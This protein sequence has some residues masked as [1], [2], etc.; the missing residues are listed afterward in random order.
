MS[1]EISDCISR[2]Y[3]LEIDKL[4]HWDHFLCLKVLIFHRDLQFEDKKNHS[5]SGFQMIFIL[6]PLLLVSE[7]GIQSECHSAMRTGVTFFKTWIFRTNTE[8]H[9]Q[10]SGWGMHP[11]RDVIL[12]SSV[13]SCYWRSAKSKIRHQR[14]Q[15]Y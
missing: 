9:W 7:R 14:Y 4:I 11:C 5:G 15:N 2:T 3:Y 1:V 8:Q 13:C 6:I 12:S 10:Q